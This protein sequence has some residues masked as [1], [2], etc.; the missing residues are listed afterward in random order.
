MQQRASRG[1]RQ[2]E[3]EVDLTFTSFDDLVAKLTRQL[4]A[5][6]EQRPVV[7]VKVDGGQTPDEAGPR[8]HVAA[9]TR[10]AR[11]RRQATHV[12]LVTD[13]EMYRVP[14]VAFPSPSDVVSVVV[15]HVRSRGVVDA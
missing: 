2:T 11:R 3:G 6:F 12:Q 7:A 9:Q 5:L 8:P 14:P 4:G 15:G 13:V 10:R 1:S